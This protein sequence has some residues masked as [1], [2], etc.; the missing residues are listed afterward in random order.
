MA[1]AVAAA[2]RHLA[3]RKGVWLV[4]AV[5]SALSLFGMAAAALTLDGSAA[6]GAI[7]YWF[8]NGPDVA[9]T[10]TLSSQQEVDDMLNEKHWVNL[11]TNEHAQGELR[12]Q[13]DLFVP[14]TPATSE[15]G[16]AAT[17]LIALT[18]GTLVFARSRQ[19]IP[20]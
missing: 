15:W 14:P 3:I 19:R 4:G 20:V 1:L 16:L 11:H 5:L 7:V 6:G 12:G 18:I 13:I 2:V 10:Y 8:P 17:T 9:G